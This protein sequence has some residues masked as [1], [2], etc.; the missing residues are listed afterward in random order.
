MCKGAFILIIGFILITSSY[1]QCEDTEFAAL[2][3]DGTSAFQGCVP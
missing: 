2:L 1:Q 3:I